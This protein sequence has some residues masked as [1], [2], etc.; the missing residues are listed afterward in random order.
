MWNLF[1]KIINALKPPEE[2]EQTPEDF[3]PIEQNNQDQQQIFEEA[4]QE[5]VAVEHD[6]SPDF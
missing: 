4:P 6:I 5:P 2:P 1:E 3:P